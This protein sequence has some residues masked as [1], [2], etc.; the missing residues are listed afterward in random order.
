MTPTDHLLPETLLDRLPEGWTASAPDDGDAPELAALLRRHEERGRGWAGSGEDD[1]LIEV[2][3]QGYI[4]R[5]NVILRDAEGEVRGWASAHD[6]AAGRMLL[7][8]VVDPRLDDGRPETADLV[9]ELLFSWADAAAK[10]IGA[11]RG[12][13]VQ[14]ID[15]GAFADDPRQ[16]GW[17]ERAGYRRVRS[18][19]QMSRPVP[20]EDADLDASEELRPRAGVRIRQVERQGTGMPSEDD[21]RIVHDVLESAFADHFNSHEETFDEFIFR[22]REDPGHRWDHWWIAELVDPDTGEVEPAGALVAAVVEGEEGQ[23]AGS[24]VEYIGVLANARGRGVAK[25]LLATVIADAARRG[26]NRVGLEVDA[27]SPTRSDALYTSMGWRTRYVT[28]S[29][30]REVPVG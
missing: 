19:W 2:S 3:A 28:Q 24:Y 18:W 10:R 12:L 30:H 17:L 4:T 22:L 6:R 25:S 29:W 20:P 1:V 23:P 8:V 15:S 26:R 16:Q 27:D 11:E 13:D 5:E 9:A 7:V 21:L 14:Q